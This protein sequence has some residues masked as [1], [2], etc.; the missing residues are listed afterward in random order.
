[1]AMLGRVGHRA[2]WRQDENDD[3]MTSAGREGNLPLVMRGRRD[4]QTEGRPTPC[5]R[6]N[7]GMKSCFHEHGILGFSQDSE[8]HGLNLNGKS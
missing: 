4:G 1:M 8:F 3:S 5:R 7:S 2:G 6:E